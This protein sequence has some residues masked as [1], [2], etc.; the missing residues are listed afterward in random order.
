MAD[1]QESERIMRCPECR[2]VASIAPWVTRPIC[3][4][5]WADTVPEV[6]DGDDAYNG[7]IESAA[8]LDWRTPGPETWTAMEPFR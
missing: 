5:A 3:V 2:R 7:S 6:W 4:H 8:N 1:L